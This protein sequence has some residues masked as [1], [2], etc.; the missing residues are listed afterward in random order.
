MIKD[1]FPAFPLNLTLDTATSSRQLDRT[2]IADHKCNSR[3]MHLKNTVMSLK[4]VTVA[5]E[6]L[7]KNYE[8]D[9]VMHVEPGDRKTRL[10][11]HLKFHEL[12]LRNKRLSAIANSVL[13]GDFKNGC[14]A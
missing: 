8:R 7:K 12:Y 3:A 4:K 13:K 11:I 14:Q 6:V 2:V 5:T 10:F 9:D 1:R